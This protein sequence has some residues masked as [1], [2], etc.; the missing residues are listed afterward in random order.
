MPPGLCP[1]TG[2]GLASEEPVPPSLQPQLPQAW[3]AHP[4][5][6]APLC[7][8]PTPSVTHHRPLHHDLVSASVGVSPEWRDDTGGGGECGGEAFPCV[9][10]DFLVE[11]TF[12]GEPTRPTLQVSRCWAHLPPHCCGHLG[13]ALPSD[14]QS[15]CPEGM[16]AP[17]SHGGCNRTEA[18]LLTPSHLSRGQPLTKSA[19]GRNPGPAPRGRPS[20]PTQSRHPISLS[21]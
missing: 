6:V 21:G 19:A 8:H 15:V 4:T 10:R 16:L 2:S 13:P 17:G 7:L 1:Q 14:G 5:P 11:V 3:P 20:R 18:V 9:C 12:P